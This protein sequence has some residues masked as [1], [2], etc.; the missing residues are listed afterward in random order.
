MQIVNVNQNTP[1]WFE[2]RKMRMTA[3]NATAIGNAGAGLNTYIYNL[4]AENFSTAEKESISNKHTERGHELED[5]ALTV[6]EFE[7]GFKV[8]KVG[9]CIGGKYD[10]CSPDGLSGKVGLVE[11]KCPDDKEYLRMLVTGKIKSDYIWQ[12]QMQM[13]ITG[14]EW[15][16]FVCYNP[17]FD[18][19]ILAI[20]IWPD[21]EKVEKLKK[22]IEKGE[23]LIKEIV[24]KY[25][26][27]REGKVNV[28]K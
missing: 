9:F 21:Q 2:A 1:E 28:S 16:D 3:S 11:V 14:K 25:N 10:G 13:M 23:L 20:R 17:N 8:E 12:M 26:Q 22:G 7:T 27:I 24:T 19:S 15:C 5:E 18:K 4:C 6:Y